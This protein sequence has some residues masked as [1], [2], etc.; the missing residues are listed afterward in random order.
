LLR[1]CASDDIRSTDSGGFVDSPAVRSL[2]AQRKYLARS[3]VVYPDGVAF[4]VPLENVAIMKAVF[5]ERGVAHGPRR[6]LRL[7]SCTP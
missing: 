1:A 5:G 2:T 4:R 7:R 6:V 3:R